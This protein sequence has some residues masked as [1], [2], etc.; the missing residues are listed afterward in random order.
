MER[1]EDFVTHKELYEHTDRIKRELQR[2]ISVVSQNVSNL[3][4]VVL[5][6]VVSLEAIKENTGEM[7]STMKEFVK[8]QK[9]H[10]E[11][12][13]THDISI[14]ELQRDD[15]VK[16]EKEKGKWNLIGIITT[17]V[18]GGGWLMDAF[19]PALSEFFFKR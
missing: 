2:D 5:P 16:L 3:E 11:K 19:G 7:T 9:E 8:E 15:D 13:H 14:N 4:K 10:R 18:V 1:R 17:A 6:M 12:L